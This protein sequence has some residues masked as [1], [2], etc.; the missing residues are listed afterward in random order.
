MRKRGLQL[1]GSAARRIVVPEAKGLFFR[2]G[3]V[4]LQEGSEGDDDQRGENEEHG[5]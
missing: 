3:N 5:S 2:G 1:S 4:D